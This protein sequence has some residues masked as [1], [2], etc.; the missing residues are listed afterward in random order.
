MCSSFSFLSFSLRCKD[1]VTALCHKEDQTTRGN[2]CHSHSLPRSS[3]FSVSLV[4]FLSLPRPF[5]Q[6]PSSLFSVSL[7]P[8]LSLPRPFSQSPSSFFSV[9]LVLVSFTTS[10]VTPF[11]LSELFLLLCHQTRKE[12]TNSLSLSIFFQS[13]TNVNVSPCYSST[14]SLLLLA[15]RWLELMTNPSSLILV[16]FLSFSFAL[17]II[18]P[19]LH[20]KLT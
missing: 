18:L 8:F 11:F 4:P 12:R 19:F 10:R 13:R 14:S 6:S 1:P 17:F 7:V 2:L 5:S 9:S 3:F 15:T 16:S 20:L